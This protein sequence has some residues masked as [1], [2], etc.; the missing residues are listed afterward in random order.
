MSEL[1]N[2]K[3]IITVAKV[4]S[5]VFQPILMP[6]LCLVLL[7]QFGE[8]VNH[9]HLLDDI[10]LIYVLCILFTILFPLC[11]FGIF[12]WKGWVTDVNLTVRKERV[13]PTFLSMILFL[14]FYYLVRTNGNFHEVL[15]PAIFSCF[16]ATMVA[17]LITIYWKISIHCLGISSVAGALFGVCYA[18]N[19]NIIQLAIAMLIIAFIVGISR[20]ILN[21]HTP[22]QVVAGTILG[23]SS[24]FL[25]I[26][27][28]FYI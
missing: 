23:F 8:Q 3:I 10:L 26:I 4:F 18:I 14:F 20:I 17:A 25:G 2:N 1:A 7:L 28:N 6:T 12:Y 5:I 9:H 27:Y 13:I 15:L 22:L 21:R 24:T 19:E 11:I 16:T